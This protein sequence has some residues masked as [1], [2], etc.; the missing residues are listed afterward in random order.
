MGIKKI[1]QS[2]K[3]QKVPYEEPRCSCITHHGMDH[4]VA[5]VD[6]H[7]LL[8]Y[9]GIPC[10]YCGEPITV[11]EDEMD[12]CFRCNIAEINALKNNWYVET[13]YEPLGSNPMHQAVNEPE[14]TLDELF[15]EELLGGTSSNQ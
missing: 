12:V 9:H 5:T 1:K 11:T 10:R 14:E 4:C 7:G 8:T 2:R 6:D 3:P 15:L 13:I